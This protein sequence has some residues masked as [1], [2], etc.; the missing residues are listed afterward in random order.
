MFLKFYFL[1]SLNYYWIITFL[2]GIGWLYLLASYKLISNNL[3]FTPLFQERWHI[4][5][6]FIQ[7]ALTAETQSIFSHLTN[8]GIWSEFKN[9][10]KRTICL[11]FLEITSVI[12]FKYHVKFSIHIYI[13]IF[14]ELYKWRKLLIDSISSYRW[15]NTMGM[16][17]SIFYLSSHN[18]QRKLEILCGPLLQLWSWLSFRNKWPKKIYLLSLCN[19][20]TNLW[21]THN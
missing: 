15:I 11:Y 4:L 12:L 19:L 5:V 21:L 3:T 14:S 8:I 6:K 18:K 20:F 10:F 2:G 13:T 9:N 17:T 7:K 1:K 16:E